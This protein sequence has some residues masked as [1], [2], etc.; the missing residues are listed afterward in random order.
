MLQSHLR[1]SV[2]EPS[3]GGVVANVTGIVQTPNSELVQVNYNKMVPESMEGR[4]T[5]R[6]FGTCCWSAL[7]RQRP[8]RCG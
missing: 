6:R 2:V 1:S 5:A 8:T 4:W 3:N 7:M